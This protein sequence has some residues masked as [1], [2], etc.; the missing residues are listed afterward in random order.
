MGVWEAIFWIAICV[1]LILLP[2][3]REVRRGKMQRRRLQKPSG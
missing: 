1:I 3:G 2:D